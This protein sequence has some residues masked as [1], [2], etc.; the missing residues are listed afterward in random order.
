[1]IIYTAFAT[2]VVSCV[3]YI[4][5][6]LDSYYVGGSGQHDQQYSYKIYSTEPEVVTIFGNPLQAGRTGW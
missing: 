2:S 1:M 5:P 6:H 4:C 3:W